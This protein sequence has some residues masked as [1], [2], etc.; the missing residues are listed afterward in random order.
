MTENKHNSK[1]HFGLAIM[2]LRRPGILGMLGIGVWIISRVP[3]LSPPMY[4]VG[5]TLQKCPH[6]VR[7]LLLLCMPV[8]R[9]VE[10]MKRAV[11]AQCL[12]KRLP[13]EI[14]I[15]AYTAVFGG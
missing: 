2:K 14:Y 13:V 11:T 5:R 15:L 8:V 9:P 3:L 12:T 7:S 6:M 1:L 10:T 4:N